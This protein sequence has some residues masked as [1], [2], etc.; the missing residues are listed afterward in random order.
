ML[1]DIL[2]PMK[3]PSL[4]DSQREA[5]LTE[6][7]KKKKLCKIKGVDKFVLGLV[8]KELPIQM[9][10]LRCVDLIVRKAMGID[11]NT[12]VPKGKKQVRERNVNM[13]GC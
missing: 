1:L 4:S 9:L 5:I 7:A 13:N 3:N 8:H 2:Q 10:S 12:K 6:L 11:S